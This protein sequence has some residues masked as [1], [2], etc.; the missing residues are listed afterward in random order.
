MF[1]GQNS[2]NSVVH[3]FISVFAR[4]RFGDTYPLRLNRDRCFTLTAN[5]SIQVGG[6]IDVFRCNHD[7]GLWGICLET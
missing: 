4:D 5:R 6:V 7:Q 1:P 2:K 3:D